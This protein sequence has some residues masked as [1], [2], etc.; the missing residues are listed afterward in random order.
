MAICSARGLD[1]DTL[2]LFY[3][4]ENMGYR[5]FHMELNPLCLTQCAEFSFIHESLIH[6]AIGFES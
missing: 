4:L 6:H 3:K 2:P 1:N 5:L